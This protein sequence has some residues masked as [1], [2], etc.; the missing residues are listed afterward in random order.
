MFSKT[1]FMMN[2]VKNKDN[3]IRTKLGGMV[4]SPNACRSKEKVIKIRVKLVINISAAGKNDK[5][6]RART[7]STGTEKVVPEPPF[8]EVTSGKA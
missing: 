7:V 2:R 5:A 8:L 1:G 4:V 3:P 6:V